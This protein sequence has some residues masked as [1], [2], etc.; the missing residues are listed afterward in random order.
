M[1]AAGHQQ[2]VKKDQRQQL[3]AQPIK[4]RILNPL[5]GRGR[6]LGRN[7]HQLRQRALRQRKALIEA[8]H[9]QRGDDGQGE[10]NSHAQRGSLARARV[11]FHFAADLLDIGANH[12]HAHAPAAD[13]G[14]GRGGRKA[15]HKNQLQQL[16]LTL[17]R[18]ALRGNQPALHGLL[19]D[20]F[21]G[22]A[23]PVVV[24]LDDY[25]AA[26]L[27]G[28]QLERSFRVL[29][30]GLAHIG[31]L[32]AVIERVSYRVGE[33]VLD[34]LEQTLVQLRVLAF[35]LQ[36]HAAAKRL[37]QIADDAR[38]LGKNI[39]YRLHSSFHHALAQVG[40]DHIQAARKQRHPG[41][42][43]GGLQD[44]IACK[45][46]FAHQ[47][48][49]PVEQRHIDT[50]R[51][52]GS[53][54]P[55]A[56]TNLVAF[57]LHR[58]HGSGRCGLCGFLGNRLKHRRLRALGLCGK[59]ERGS[60]ASP[61]MGRMFCPRLRRNLQLFQPAD[62]A[63]ILAL[64]F[65]A[66]RLDCLEDGA[67]PVEQVQ[68]ARD[69]RTV[70]GQLALAQLT[71]QVFSGVGQRFQPLEPQ[72]SGGS[73]DGM[74]RTEDLSNQSRILGPLLQIGQTALHAVQ[75]FLALDQEFPR[76]LIHRA[77]SSARPE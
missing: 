58:S 12:V 31:R 51:T 13:V 40:R 21:Y 30:R 35:D 53:G 71:Q 57:G 4:G 41:I 19:A 50:Q 2:P 26:L 8:A 6:L 34:G 54:S 56:R 14:H 9:N 60:G 44:L 3:A 55:R 68:Q 16:P 29:A 74:H 20:F 18:C 25:V 10:R 5:D 49:H 27:R 28:P 22:D 36:P 17:A 37:R 70:R 61:G 76:Q 75:S 42:G 46:Q 64:A 73:L 48:H 38:H 1:L 59:N 7:M 65:V 11:D 45:H 24:D 32:D 72:E 39:R 77:H 67:Q 63:G 66:I 23:G 52:L 69:N 47:V 43:R 33:R 62:Q 15:G